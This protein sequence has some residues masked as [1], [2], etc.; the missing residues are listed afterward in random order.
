[1][2]QTAAQHQGCPVAPGTPQERIRRWSA[3]QPWLQADP[4]GAWQEIR[5]YGPVLRSEEFG[6]YWILTR[7]ADI[8]WA[9]RNPDLFSS[10]D[11]GI[12]NRQI[13]KD[14]LI[15]IQLDGEDHRKWRQALSA[16]FNP[17]VVNHITPQIREAAVDAIEPI[18]AR[19]S[20]EFV[21]DFA[22]RLPAETFLI[23]FGI[24][25][26]YL[27]ELLDHKN[28]L[29]REGLPNARN[30]EEL[31]A[32]GRPLWEFFSA[33]V[34]ARRAEGIEGRR[35]VISSLLRAEHE[36]RPLTQDEI[37]NIILMTMFASLDTSNS[38]LSMVFRHL[39]EHPGT[40]RTVVEE[41]HRVPAMAEELIRHEAMVSTARVVTREVELHDVKLRVGDRVLMSWGMAG[42]DPEV[43]ER[44]DEVDFDRQSAR[45]LAFGIG[46]HRCL[47]MHLARR[48]VKVALEEWHAR[49]PEYHITPGTEPVSRYSPIRGLD[50]LD[51]TLGAA[52]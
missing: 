42:I 21:E 47:G 35:D 15:P 7:Y 2:N 18:A 44:A 10:A 28:W 48:I 20:C 31:H 40:Q 46:P 50:R 33:A 19:G 22:V 38:L 23:N 29:R 30:D 32:A 8:E 24:D 39:A 11:I 37:V 9:A 4:V 16:L 14:K 41:P 26:S 43:F 3:Y 51:L 12:P 49:I 34:D 1:M 13:Y 6:G 27:P 25:R 5:E 52:R 45:H 36:G 17:A